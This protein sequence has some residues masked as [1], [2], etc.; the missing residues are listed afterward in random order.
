M[1]NSKE[2]ISYFSNFSIMFQHE[3]LEARNFI[4]YSC[5]NHVSEWNIEKKKLRNSFVSL[6]CSFAETC[7]GF[8][9]SLQWIP[10]WL[11][12]NSTRFAVNSTSWKVESTVGQSG[13]GCK[14]KWNPLEAEVESTA[15]FSE[16]THQWNKW[17]SKILLSQFFM[18]KHGW[19][20]NKI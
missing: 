13:I 20:M 2:E 6:M 1:K 19:H 4:F 16:R 8:H 11:T 7:S 5:I 18:L 10:L 15:S 3:K 17:N 12:V 9:F 14:P